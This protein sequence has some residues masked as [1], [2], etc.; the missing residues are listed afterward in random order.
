[1]H[2]YDLTSHVILSTIPKKYFS[3]TLPTPGIS[4]NEA[5]G[6]MESQR[7]ELSLLNG[8]LKNHSCNHSVYDTNCICILSFVH[9]LS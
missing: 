5:M 3:P 7:K 6:A 4:M 9:F 8:F 2:S 1:M